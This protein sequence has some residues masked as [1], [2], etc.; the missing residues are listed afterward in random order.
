MAFWGH[1]ERRSAYGLETVASVRR[2][3]G[4]RSRSALPSTPD[5]RIKVSQG[6]IDPSVNVR[7]ELAQLVAG[8]IDSVE[9]SERLG[10]GAVLFVAQTVEAIN[11]SAVV[12]VSHD[13]LAATMGGTRWIVLVSTLNA[14]GMTG[15]GGSS[16]KGDG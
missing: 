16:S 3:V 8:A 7:S 2:R 14:C 10:L 11:A 1:R 13:P 6:P 5:E 4:S 9:K 15:G 12:E